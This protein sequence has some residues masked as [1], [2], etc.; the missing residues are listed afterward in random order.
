MAGRLFSGLLFLFSS[1]IFAGEPSLAEETNCFSGPFASYR[2]WIL[3]LDKKGAAFDETKFG[4]RFPEEEYAAFRASLRCVWF[5]YEVEGVA[6]PGFMVAPKTGE[7][8]PAIIFNRGGNAEAGLI[9]PA[10]LM[11]RIFPIAAAGFVV[12]GS[13]YRG[14]RLSDASARERHPDEFGGQ[15]VDDVLSLLEILDAMP[16]VDATKVG[17]LGWSRGGMMSYLIARK[18]KRISSVAVI[19]APTDLQAE[20]DFRPEMEAIFK[21]YIP[22]YAVKKDERLQER[23]ALAW[24]DELS[25]DVPILLLHGA[26]DKRVSPMSSINMAARLLKLDRYFK[27][28]VY[29]GAGHELLGNED[30]V[31]AETVQWFR[32]TLSTR[33]RLEPSNSPTR[34]NDP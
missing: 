34:P 22:D 27:L 32:K 14:T 1:A 9:N 31:L 30:D 5:T 26:S 10:Y 6:T 24:V 33:P 18:S 29:D 17:T 7:A 23:S 4:A 25:S 21:V 20:L 12:I 15:D 13:Q 2:S 11:S 8:L 3:E 16:N 28:V 19:G